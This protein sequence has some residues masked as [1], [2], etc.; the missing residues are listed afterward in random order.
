MFYSLKEPN[1]LDLVE[2]QKINHLDQLL[3]EL[4]EPN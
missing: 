3:W 4:Q 2:H 1:Q